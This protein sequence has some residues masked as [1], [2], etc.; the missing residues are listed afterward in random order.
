VA[1]LAALALVATAAAPAW[2]TAPPSGRP[3]AAVEFS[4]AKA[5]HPVRPIPAARRHPTEAA[6]AWAWL[7]LGAAA[8][9]LVALAFAVVKL[10]RGPQAFV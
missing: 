9:L 8:A 3:A 5:A 2:A 7:A 10:A 4:H 1:L 6:P